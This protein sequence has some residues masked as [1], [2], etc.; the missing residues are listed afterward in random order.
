MA[1]VAS[2]TFTATSAPIQ[3]AAIEAFR[4]GPEIESYL[5]T[6]RKILCALGQHCASKLRGA[7]L[8]LG[9]PDGGFYLF[10]DFE[11]F[12]HE[13]EERGMSSSDELCAQLLEQTGVATVPGSAFGR[14]KDELTLRLAYVDFDGAEAMRAADALS[15]EEALD[16][17]FLRLY[18]PRVTDGIDRLQDWLSSIAL[19]ERSFQL[20]GAVPVRRRA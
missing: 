5:S 14:S 1:A 3:F 17:A 19:R 13:L 10:P 6:S 20:E 7:G 15:R 11:A 12:K 8:R 2:E 4:G 18:C 9:T 16:E